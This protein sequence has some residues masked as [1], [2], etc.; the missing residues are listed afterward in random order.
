MASSLLDRRHRGSVAWEYDTPWFEKHANAILR[1]VAGNWLFSGAWIYESPEYA[2]PQSALDANL[3]GDAATDRGPQY[4]WE[5]VCISSDVT[6]LT[7][8]R[9]GSNQ[10]VAYAVNDP[11]AYYIRARPGMF[12]TAAAIFFVCGRS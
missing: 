3:N 10:T 7:S 11:T 4:D 6:A 2:T 9:N 5:P 12:T 8:L 1:N